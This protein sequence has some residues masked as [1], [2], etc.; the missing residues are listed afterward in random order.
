MSTVG[1]ERR[2]IGTGRTGASISP[3]GPLILMSVAVVFACFFAIGR[4]TDTGSA[5]PTEP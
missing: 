3:R 5:T 4:A 1:L 2:R